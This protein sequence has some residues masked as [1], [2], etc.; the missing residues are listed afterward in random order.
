ML[1]HVWQIDL[2]IQILTIL[3]KNQLKIAVI[4]LC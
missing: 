4:C 2:E 1:F 3:K